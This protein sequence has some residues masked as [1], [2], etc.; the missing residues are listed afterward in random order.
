MKSHV[1]EFSWKGLFGVL[2]P[3]LIPLAV[4]GAIMHLGIWTKVLPS[5]RP[6]LD[7][8]H[9]ILIH[10]VESAQKR[11]AADLVLIGDS[12]CLMNVSAKDA[13]EQLGLKVL[14]LGSLSYLDLN[15][16]AAILQ[17][18][19]S[20][21]PGSPR[22]VVLLMHP[23]A[24][25]QPGP[26]RYYTNLLHQLLTGTAPAQIGGTVKPF[27][28]LIGADEFRARI[29]IRSLPVPLSGAYGSRYGFTH[30][31]ENYM[32]ANHG[33][34]IDPTARTF[35]GN[36]EYG[37]AKHIERASPAFRRAIPEG[38][39][40]KVAITPV[41]ES[42]P[43]KHYRETHAEMLKQWSEWLGAE[44]LQLPATMPD[45]YFVSTTHLNE[46]G[47]AAYTKILG[48]AL[49]ARIR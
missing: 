2:I 27:E 32:E 14:N 49:A 42:F 37:L 20:S 1:Y 18:Y 10:Q 12:S 44:P 33:S 8:D 19:I 29:L 3:P 31:L 5:P 40:L 47:V 46:R 16:H 39:R 28:Q 38:V 43:G 7:V 23:E 45:D 11:S 25:R 15:S 17:Q 6:A 24:L 22:E 4:F 36:A 13:G 26:E 21:N 9:T 35:K 34:V 48:E 41:P 30:D